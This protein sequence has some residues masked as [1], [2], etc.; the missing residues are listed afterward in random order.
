M[1]RYYADLNPRALD[2]PWG[3]AESVQDIGAG[4]LHVTTAS[5][6]GYF[7]PRELN[8]LIPLAWR[9]HTFV[10]R[11]MI[12]W[13]EEDC[14]WCLVALAFPTTFPPPHAADA[15]KRMFDATIAKKIGR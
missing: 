1:D 6:G 11:G 3:P 2:T 4:I 7:V 9:T 12:G 8:A 10:A 14:D 13:Y 5:H 15:A